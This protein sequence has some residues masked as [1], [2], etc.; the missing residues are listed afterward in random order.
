MQCLR[1]V[2]DDIYGQGRVL[3]H[4]EEVFVPSALPLAFQEQEGLCN[5]PEQ[6]AGNGFIFRVGQ[7][8]PGRDGCHDNEKI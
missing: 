7:G 2:L 8:G 1:E 5:R 6:G 4:S 3:Q